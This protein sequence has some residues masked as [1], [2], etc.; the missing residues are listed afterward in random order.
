M[1]WLFKHCDK[2]LFN[3][4]LIVKF[5]NA[6]CLFWLFFLM[7]L[8]CI[9]IS[10]FIFSSKSYL[11]SCL[12][13]T[14]SVGKQTENP[15]VLELSPICLWIKSLHLCVWTQCVRKCENV[16]GTIFFLVFCMSLAEMASSS[17][18]CWFFLLEICHYHMVSKVC[19]PKYYLLSFL[20]IH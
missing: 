9:S 18:F 15:I 6:Q 4:C 12:K 19:F 10:M 11:R 20:L 13:V 3:D 16:S 1:L 5:F 14:L 8:E 7:T 2:S 17:C